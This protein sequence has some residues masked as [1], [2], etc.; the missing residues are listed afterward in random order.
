[1]E[2]WS[3]HQLYL[4]AKDSLGKD[5]ASNLRLYAENL[6]MRGLPVV[7]SLRHLSHLTDVNYWFLHETVNRKRERS[8]YRMYA[9]RKRSGGRRFIHAVTSQLLRAQSWINS[10]ILQKCAPHPASYAFHGSRGIK[11]C[12]SAHCG[13][14]WLFQFDLTDFF[15]DISEIDC[16]RVFRRIGY[17]ALL[18][19]EL[20]RICTTTRLPRWCPR[21]DYHGYGSVWV[22]DEDTYRDE[23]IDLD[24]P[25]KRPYYER[26]GRLGALAQ[27]APSSPMLSNL[28]AVELDEALHSYALEKGFVYTRY[29]DDITF[30]A[31]E[32]GVG[33]KRIRH[34]VIT[35]IRK[36]GY[37]ENKSKC[38]IAG[39][40]SKKLVLGLLVD[41]NE[42]RISKETYKRI[43]RMLHGVLNYG[44]ESTAKHFAFES[45]Y[46]FHNHLCGLIAYVKSVDERRHGEFLR[47]LNDAKERW[48]A[49]NDI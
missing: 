35:I 4:K 16:Y 14:K 49:H 11:D 9:I 15:Y 24:V 17:R 2:S 28:A 41:G 13:A 5:V 40:G 25:T 42:P 37:I 48:S 26:F 38:R 8:N 39:P 47:R 27:G 43:D 18:A 36:A 46:G 33:R 7:F 21:A 45:A 1:M 6:R 12:A 23:L 19:F 22:F 10:E 34:D 3:A 32:L 44:I 29:A 31:T 30:S 20:A